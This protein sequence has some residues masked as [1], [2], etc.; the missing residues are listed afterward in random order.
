M[1]VNSR[2]Y[3]AFKKRKASLL[4]ATAVVSLMIGSAA[5]SADVTIT[6]G[7]TVG[8]QSLNDG[9]TLI[10]E[11][12]ATINSTTPGVVD[13]V[14]GTTIT[15]ENDGTITATTFSAIDNLASTLNL[16]NNGSI[17]GADNGINSQHIDTFSNT[18][19]IV[20]SNNGIYV[21]GDTNQ[22]TN[23]GSITGVSVFGLLGDG[24]LTSLMNSGLMT[25]GMAA[26]SYTSIDSLTNSG[27]L[28]GTLNGIEADYLTSITNE[29][30]ITGVNGFGIQVLMDL[31][32]LKNTG[33]IS[34]EVDG[35]LTG[36]KL[37]SLTNTGLITGVLG[38]GIDT[39]DLFGYLYNT[40]T[41]S[42]AS[43]GV[44][45]ENLGSV[46]NSGLITGADGLYSNDSL[47]S[48][49]NTGTI[50]GNCSCVL[51]S[52]VY[53]Y[54]TAQ[55]IVNT[56]SITGTDSGIDA[57]DLNTLLNTGTI[58]GENTDGVYVDGGTI[59]SLINTGSIGGAIHAVDARYVTLLTNT[60]S[61]TG[62][63]DG[64]FAQSILAL[65]NSGSITGTSDDGIL[66]E[67]LGVLVN[68]GSIAGGD[69]GIDVQYIATL[70]NNG[71]ITGQDEGVK[72]REITLLTNNGT[73]TGGSAP[74]ESGIDTDFGTIVNN[75]LIQG[76]IGIEFDRD[77]SGGANLGNSKVTN[78]GAIKS[79]SGASGVAI[80]FQQTGSDTLTLGANSVIVG[81][82]AWDGV[83]D[84]LNL[85]SNVSNVIKF[86]NLPDTIN[87][88]SN[89]VVFDGT[90]LIQVDTTF[91]ASIDDV[92]GATS[93]SVN[94][95]V[96]NQLNDAVFGNSST[97][98]QAYNSV[99]GDGV[100]SVW[101][102]NWFSYNQLDTSNNLS[103]DTT[104]S[105]GSLFGIDRT[106]QI[107]T[108]YGAYAGF[109]ISHTK[110][111]STFSHEIDA[112]SLILGVYSQ[113]ETHD[114]NVGINLQAGKVRFD[115]ARMIANTTVASGVETASANYDS[116]YFAPNLNL[117]KEI[118][119]NDGFS[120][121]PS[122]S[123][124]YTGLYV[125]GYSETGSSANASIASRTIHQLQ[126]RAKLGARFDWVSDNDVGY[127]FMPYAG[128]EGRIASGD[129]DQVT[130]TVAGTSTTFNP[131]GD[132]NTGAA[133]AGLNINAK[134]SETAR[135]ESAFEAK[136]DSSN[137]FA[138]TGSWGV[139]F[140]F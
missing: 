3:S 96:S 121:I 79:T 41:I 19:D 36:G 31:G 113:F 62:G 140:K 16:T 39:G 21:T 114:L 4:T 108:K 23:S 51:G 50:S 84:T 26:V 112:D 127:V 86:S 66:A 118:I 58:W 105:M 85:V 99:D 125:D 60:G 67:S 64:I 33:T 37:D 136:Y 75:G 138:V 32:T 1:F 102:S 130:G 82:V 30:L 133:F 40:G 126:A 63:D 110:V 9:D 131:G 22:F 81:S 100:K 72:A 24:T 48:L 106:N 70:T 52:G 73:I 88:Q 87:N 98:A 68:D 83:D 57:R 14:D 42:G 80:D 124:G 18:A 35:I 12:G 43:A 2:Q 17:S 89:F 69:D 116:F 45:A 49:L 46:I 93:N 103:D 27:T 34:G 13:A 29:G 55:T 44:D 134:L 78:N 38:G 119:R 92:V 5:F 128:L 76:G 135:F 90:T 15:V 120:L 97:Q 6:S 115:S 117:S 54:N 91:L 65:A 47:V 28:S 25:G 59:G 20:G 71:S 94:N 139:K 107:G 56:G 95:A 137:Q 111:G 10:I 101:N 8:Q 7:S 122:L 132:K 109:G 104:Q 129:I 123:L 11:N 77:N 61:L 53:V 74:D